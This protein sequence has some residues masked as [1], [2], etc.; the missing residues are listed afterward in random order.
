MFDI[1]LWPFRLLWH[2]FVWIIAQLFNILIWL[3]G[4]IFALAKDILFLLTSHLF[5][6][7]ENVI[8][9]YPGISMA[10]LPT[11]WLSWRKWVD[12]NA[13]NLITPKN[14][15]TRP[16]FIVVVLTPIFIA[17]LSSFVQ[18]G[19]SSTAGVRFLI[20]LNNP[21]IIISFSIFVLFSIYMI[22]LKIG[23]IRRSPDPDILKLLMRYSFIV[24]LVTVVCGFALAGYQTYKT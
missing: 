12:Y 10:I 5:T 14:F 6:L 20:E 22:L 1:L 11:A 18:Q 21:F 24:T 16:T 4:Q 9:D 23:V 3:L 15:W 17:I 13:K 19:S 7:Y 2:L 8:V